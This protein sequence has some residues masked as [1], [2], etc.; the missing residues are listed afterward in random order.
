MFRIE[1]VALHRFGEAAQQVTLMSQ[2]RKWPV[3]YRFRFFRPPDSGW[4]LGGIDIQ[5]DVGRFPWDEAEAE[6]LR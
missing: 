6:T 4:M 5:S 3:L 2:H 1:P